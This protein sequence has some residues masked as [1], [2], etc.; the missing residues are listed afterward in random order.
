MSELQQMIKRAREALAARRPPLPAPTVGLQAFWSAADIEEY[1][2]F[3][4]G[5]PLPTSE[6]ALDLLATD[7]EVDWLV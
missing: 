1:C 7:V 2:R 6:G 4:S 3:K 5:G